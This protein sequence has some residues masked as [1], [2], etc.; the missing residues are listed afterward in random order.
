[1]DI[2]SPIFERQGY[3]CNET[4]YIII[5]EI[6]D[7]SSEIG[8]KA[9]ETTRKQEKNNLGTGETSGTQKDTKG[10]TN[11]SLLSVV[12]AICCGPN[13]LIQTN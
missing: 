13:C 8:Q 5:T 11:N 7:L 6:D 12:A 2:W 10:I 1:M 4:G 9:S 3:A